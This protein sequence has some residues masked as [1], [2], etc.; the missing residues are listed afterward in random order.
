MKEGRATIS[1]SRQLTLLL[2]S[3]IHGNSENG[4]MEQVIL[5]KHNLEP[6]KQIKIKTMEDVGVETKVMSNWQWQ[7]LREKSSSSQQQTCKRQ[8][9]N[10][11]YKA[12]GC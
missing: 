12:S 6:T 10:S 4:I 7:V 9:A 8:I 1:F 2:N 5:S 11:I 3:E